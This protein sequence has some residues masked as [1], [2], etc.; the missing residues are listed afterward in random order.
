MPSVQARS[1]AGAQG[2][3]APGRGRPVACPWCGRG[4][5]IDAGL[6]SEL[7]GLDDAA[8]QARFHT[9]RR[10]PRDLAR[11]HAVWA[12]IRSRTAAAD[13]VR[14]RTRRAS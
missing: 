12:F 1:A 5:H 6:V 8:L 7:A 11:E 14:A 9:A 2:R 13:R 4:F 10:P 3:V